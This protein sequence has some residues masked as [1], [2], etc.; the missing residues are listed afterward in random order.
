M[1][2]QVFQL[3]TTR[4]S[5]VGCMGVAPRWVVVYVSI[6]LNTSSDNSSGEVMHS[7]RKAVVISLRVASV[8]AFFGSIDVVKWPWLQQQK[9]II[10][11]LFIMKFKMI[12][13]V[14]RELVITKELL[15]YPS[16]I[17]DFALNFALKGYYVRGIKSTSWLKL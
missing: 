1:C 5:S 6:P 4:R 12:N 16:S 17:V 9:S 11:V 15:S 14:K 8:D 7:G 2:F 3:L 10:L 13:G